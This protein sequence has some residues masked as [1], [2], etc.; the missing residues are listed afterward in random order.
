MKNKV[1]NCLESLGFTLI[2]NDKSSRKIFVY[3]NV[4]VSVEDQLSKRQ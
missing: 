1:I 4:L 2:S 3:G